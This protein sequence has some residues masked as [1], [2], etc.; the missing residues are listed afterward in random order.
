ME[1]EAFRAP[2]PVSPE[3]HIRTRSRERQTEPFLRGPVP[4][5]WL[6]LAAA[7]GRAALATGAAL[8]FKQGLRRGETVP[9]KVNASVR[10]A[11]GLSKDQARRGIH[12]LARAG[13]V[14]VRAGGRGRCAEVEIVATTTKPTVE[15]PTVTPPARD[16]KTGW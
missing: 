12:A 11:M 1:L 13:L 8:W 9:I 4:M 2:N 7:A 15:S 16:S 10:R 6:F 3:P 5:A 14:V